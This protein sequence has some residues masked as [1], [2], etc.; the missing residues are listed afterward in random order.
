MPAQNAKRGLEDDLGRAHRPAPLGFHQ[1]QSLQET[2]N[3]YQHAGKF[4]TD[5]GKRTFDTQACGQGDV[6]QLGNPVTI[7]SSSGAD[8][9]S[10]LAPS[11]GM[12]CP[13][14]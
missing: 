14:E 13:R 10:Q 11:R 2:A 5:C 1:L 4:R 8:A 12:I 3:I 6:C 7:G 9:R